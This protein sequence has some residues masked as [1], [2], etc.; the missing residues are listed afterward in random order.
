MGT[1]SRAYNAK[2]WKPAVYS[3]TELHDEKSSN[4]L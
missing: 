2:D 4:T 1:R 3:V